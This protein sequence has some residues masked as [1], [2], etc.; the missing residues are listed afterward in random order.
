LFQQQGHR[1]SQTTTTRT[2]NILHD[3][4]DT[5]SNSDDNNSDRSVPGTPNAYDATDRVATDRGSR[6]G[7]S[8]VLRRLSHIEKRRMAR[9][10]ND[11]EQI[12]TA[13]VRS[14]IQYNEL[15]KSLTARLK[16]IQVY[17]KVKKKK[18]KK[19]GREMC[20]TT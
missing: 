13:E 1:V 19:K 9:L 4:E 10:R 17:T 2:S 5:S 14:Q 20:M 16:F 7:S 11:D 6:G 15:R 18:K 3:R 8:L 12:A